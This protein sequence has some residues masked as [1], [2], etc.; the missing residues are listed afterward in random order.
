MRA[1]RIDAWSDSELQK[2]YDY[3][4]D[5]AYFEKV[6]GW[7]PNRSVAAIRQRMAKLRVEAGIDIRACEWGLETR[8]RA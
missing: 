4:N 2:L 1:T 8:R 5:P 3:V 7:L 6:R